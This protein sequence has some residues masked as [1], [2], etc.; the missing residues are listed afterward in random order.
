MRN[1]TDNARYL[2]ASD[3]EL[4]A[5]GFTPARRERLLRLRAM[6]A[7]WVENPRLTDKEI[8][9]EIRARYGIGRRAAQED[10]AALQICL[11]EL[12]QQTTD[13]YRYVFLQRCEELFAIA[14]AKGDVKAFASAL[15]AYGRFTR[16]D[17]DETSTP[18]YQQ[19]VPQNF[20][21]SDNPEDAGFARLPNAEEVAERLLEKYKKSS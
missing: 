14:R 5:A 15:T 20:I 9:Q 19:I 12:A 10:T 21:I 11:G 7:Y 6:Y 17:R 13:Y 4:R 2:F 1:Q 3:D 8:V 18:D 16:I